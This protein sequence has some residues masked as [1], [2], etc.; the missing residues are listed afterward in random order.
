MGYM[1]TVYK[2]RGWNYHCFHLNHIGGYLISSS[3]TPENKF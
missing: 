1:C 2:Q 3:G